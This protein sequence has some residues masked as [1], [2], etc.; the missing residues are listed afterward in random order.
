MKNDEK[1]QLASNQDV[2]GA[3]PAPQPELSISD[4]QNLR[5]IVETAAKRG[6]FAANEMSAVGAVY[7]RVT[8]FLNAVTPQPAQ[9]TEAAA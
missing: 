8:N 2:G 9:D 7:D 1:A 5:T 3:P 4:L 6:A